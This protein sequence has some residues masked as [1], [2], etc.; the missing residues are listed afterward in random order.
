[1]RMTKIVTAFAV[2]VLLTA[3]ANHKEP[4][5]K[6]VA[7]IEASFN[8]LKADAGKYA[9]EELKGVEESIAKLKSQIGKQDFESVVR[10]APYVASSLSSLKNTVATRKAEAEELL[11]A[12]QQE[13]TDLSASVPALV[14]RL[15]SRMDTLTRSRVTPRG[16]DK[17][18]FETAKQDFEKVKTSWTEASSEFASGMAA[19]AVRKARAAKAKGEHLAQ[20]LGA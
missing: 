5:E 7:Q 19:S 18:S 8:E 17:A 4:A 14:T 13:W 20:K 6:A 1:M 2:A 16:F 10:Q 12:A 3:C 11:A 15:Q 9:A